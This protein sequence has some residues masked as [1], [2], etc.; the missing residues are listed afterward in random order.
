MKQKV[1]APFRARFQRGLG[2]S[3]VSL[4]F[5]DISPASKSPSVSVSEGHRS[6]TG[7]ARVLLTLVARNPRIVEETLAD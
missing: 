4:T 3:C 1:N 6:P 7:P 5:L 2:A